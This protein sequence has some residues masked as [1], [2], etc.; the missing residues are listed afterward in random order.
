MIERYI[1]VNSLTIYGLMYIYINIYSQFTK[2]QKNETWILDHKEWIYCLTAKRWK[3][4]I[5]TFTFTFW[6]VYV[7][8]PFVINKAQTSA[9]AIPRN[10]A[11]VVR[12]FYVCIANSYIAA[13]STARLLARRVGLCNVTRLTSAES[14][15]I[16]GY[17]CTRFR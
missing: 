12:N 8:L 9:A 11:C 3:Q 15:R 6:H 13:V 14:P 17:T 5:A 16:A 10:D 1:I 7:L 4:I 2:P